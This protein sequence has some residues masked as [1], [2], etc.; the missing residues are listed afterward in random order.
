VVAPKVN[1][2]V[3]SVDEIVA[4]VAISAPSRY[5][6]AAPPVASPGIIVAVAVKLVF[7]ADNLLLVTVP[8]SGVNTSPVGAV[9]ATVSIT[10]AALAAKDPADPGL[11]SVLLAVFPTMSRMV[12]PF[13]T[14]ASTD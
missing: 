9:G 14:K 8:P 5:N 4:S 12:P 13:N 3:E 11:I 7:V 6:I 2:A 1:V 10:R